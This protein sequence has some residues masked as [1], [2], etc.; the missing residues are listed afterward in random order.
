MLSLAGSMRGWA[1]HTERI[2][3]SYRN[4][5]IKKIHIAKRDLGM[6][7]ETYRDF[8]ERETNKTSC[9]D[10]SEDQM[11][12]VMDKFAELG[13]KPNIKGTFRA[14]S[15]K[16]Y[17]RKIYAIWGQLC[18]DGIWR[19]KKRS[20]LV[21]FVKEHVGC[22]DPEWLTQ[23]QASKVIYALQAMVNQGRKL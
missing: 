7:D 10:L 5:L 14:P 23:E 13:W 1:S 19:N 16:P 11:R 12:H 4:A 21:T 17:V 6:N 2:P 9:K 8:L 3:M 22:E 15:K 20:S 18:R